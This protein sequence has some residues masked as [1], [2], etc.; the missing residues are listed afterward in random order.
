[1]LGGQQRG[2]PAVGDLARQGGVPGADCRQVDRDLRLHRR[3]RQLERLAGAIGQR[4]LERRAVKLDAFARQRHAHYR[5]VVARALQLPRES[6]PVPTLGDLRA[7]GADAEHHA[8]ARQL[9]D[10]GGGHRGH[11]RGAGG[12]LEDP[13][14]QPDATGLPGKPPQHGRRVRAV[15]LCR[16]DR[17]IAQALCLP[18]D[19]QLIIRA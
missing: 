9:I 14:A 4:Q 3:D 1:M 13:R 10:R 5:H 18:D 6:L 8:P 15:G 7:G 2:Y 11:R 12:H 17:V 19:L 16:P